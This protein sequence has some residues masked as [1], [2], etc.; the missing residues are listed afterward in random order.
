MATANKTILVSVIV[1]RGVLVLDKITHPIGAEV[2]LAED[3]AQRLLSLGVVALPEVTAATPPTAAEAA[4]TA[5]SSDG[6][7]VTSVQE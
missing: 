2:R 1:R 3:E 7:S 6:P 4:P 5:T